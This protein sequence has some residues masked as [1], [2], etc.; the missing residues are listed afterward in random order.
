VCECATGLAYLGDAARVQQ[1]LVNLLSNAVKFTPAGGRVQLHCGTT[2]RPA[3]ALEAPPAMAWT[4]F[5]VEDMGIGIGPELL[6][7]IFQPFVQ[8][9]GGYTRAHSGTGSG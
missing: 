7:W 9:E 4:Y 6:E 1:V 8:G 3:V 5:S 2:D